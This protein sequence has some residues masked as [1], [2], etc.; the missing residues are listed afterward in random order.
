MKRSNS[1]QWNFTAVKIALPARK[2]INFSRQSNRYAA[3]RRLFNDSFLQITAFNNYYVTG[4]RNV[5]FLIL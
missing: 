5:K 1:P 2:I 4:Y 3:K